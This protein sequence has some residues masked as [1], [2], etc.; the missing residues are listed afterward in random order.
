MKE[1]TSTP[2]LGQS[3]VG[4]GPEKV[5]RPCGMGQQEPSTMWKAVAPD[6]A[7]GTT[8]VS[9]PASPGPGR[10]GI[11]APPQARSPS[12]RRAL[13]RMHIALRATVMR[14]HPTWC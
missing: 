2:G 4:W 5:K 13:L 7:R 1:A 10:A 8:E 12:I 6:E 9:L 11:W 3:D 14:I